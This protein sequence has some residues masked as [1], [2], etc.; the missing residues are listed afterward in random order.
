MDAGPDADPEARAAP[1]LPLPPSRSLFAESLGPGS[2]C[3]GGTRGGR[4]RGRLCSSVCS[5]TQSSSCFSRSFQYSVSRDSA[6]QESLRASASAPRA[7]WAETENAL[8][9]RGPAAG[10]QAGQ[11]AR[12]ARA[13]LHRCHYGRWPMGASGGL[14][15]RDN[16]DGAWTLTKRPAVPPPDSDD[17]SGGCFRALLERGRRRCQTPAPS[18]VPAH[19]ATARFSAHVV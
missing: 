1:R 2:A 5:T 7:A 19:V 4:A 14:G 18:S 15:R 16:G 9:T 10:G 12:Y 6:S 13:P 8:P 17:D 11:P 3:G